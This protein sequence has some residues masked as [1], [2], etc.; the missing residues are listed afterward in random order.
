[1][2][3][4][5]EV[6]LETVKALYDKLLADAQPVK[7]IDQVTTALTTVGGT[8]K[9]DLAAAFPDLH[10]GFDEGEK[11][12]HGF[13]MSAITALTARI[14]ALEGQAPVQKSATTT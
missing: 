11:Q 5:P 1:M 3:G 2:G 14:A 7:A 10:A 8:I 6:S 12:L 13:F 9:A 4:K